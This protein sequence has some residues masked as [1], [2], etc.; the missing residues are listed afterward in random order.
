MPDLSDLLA[1]S[2]PRYEGSVD[3]AGIVRR[4]NRTARRQ[5]L[6][7]LAVPV[8][9]LTGLALALRWVPSSTVEFIAP[10]PAPLPSEASAP[11]DPTGTPARPT[12][13]EV[14]SPVP[15]ATPGAAHTAP[16]VRPGPTPSQAPIEQQSAPTD[17]PVVGAG[18]P[19]PEPTP[20]QL[21]SEPPRP[22][23]AESC[24]VTT[25]DVEP[26]ESTTCSFT[27]TA[28]GGF[29]VGGRGLAQSYPKWWVEI[30]RD[31]QVRRYSQREGGTEFSTEA[32]CADDV[33][34]PGDI[35]TL[36]VRRPPPTEGV[37]H[38]TLRAGRGYGCPEQDG[39]APL[40]I[41]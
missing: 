27:A 9:M 16:P 35:V 6:A 10:V 34:A 40:S 21:D 4:G 8:V 24:T 22:P 36:T 28:A 13:T 11:E 5:R 25:E 29:W 23:Q 14:T 20:S 33:I 37:M 7:L 12:P 32:S 38:H 19:L 3:V 26:G 41:S 2:A 39:S 15:S 30:V 1:S 31:G 17:P 18:G